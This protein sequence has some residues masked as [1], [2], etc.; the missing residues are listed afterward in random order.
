MVPR[1]PYSSHPYWLRCAK[2][3]G[4]VDVLTTSLLDD[5]WVK[6]HY[7]SC[8]PAFR[9]SQIVTKPHPV[10]GYRVVDAVPDRR[11][12]ADLIG[13]VLLV[14]IAILGATLVLLIGGPT[15]ADAQAEAE[16][17]NAVI[18]MQELD[19]RVS[20]VAYTSDHGTVQ[21]I[22]VSA[23]DDDGALGT[24]ER[25]WIR[26]TIVNATTGTT[27][28]AL[29]NATL[30]TVHYTNGDT[31]VGFEGGGVWRSDR[32]GAVMVTPPA[33]SFHDRTLTLPIISLAGDPSLS[34][35]I[36]TNRAGPTV[37]LFPN[38]SE[39]RANPIDGVKVRV[40]V[41]SR[42]YEAWARYFAET[43][44]ASVRVN[45]TAETATVTF[46]ASNTGPSAFPSGIL[47]TSGNGH[48]RFAGSGAYTD[49]YDSSVGPYTD[50]R[51][52]NGTVV[53]AGDIKST[54]NSSVHG[55]VWSGSTVD[56]DGETTVNGDIY[57]TEAYFKDGAAVAGADTEIPGVASIE[58]IDWLVW[59]RVDAIRAAN[60]NNDT[61]VIQDARLNISDD[62]DGLPTET[63]DSGQYYL[64]RLVLHGE[65]LVLNTSGGNI[66]IAVRDY[67]QLDRGGPGNPGSNITVTG[68]GVV[69]IYVANRDKLL[70]EKGGDNNLDRDRSLNL[71]VSQESTTAIQ[72][73]VAPQLR[74][75]GPRGFTMAMAGSDSKVTYFNGYVY[76]PAGYAG[77]GYTYLKH[78]EV[79]G[80]I[81]TGNLTVG[82][83][84][85]IH[86]DEALSRRT[87]PNAPGLSRIEYLHATVARVN[88]SSS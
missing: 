78:A 64:T 38:R 69:R 60:D 14:G 63:L 20:N 87:I 61:P 9:A 5:S 37:Q 18:A 84:A 43:T 15:L 45:R 13:I 35:A 26:V 8:I 73:N 24:S 77:D 74:I 1:A 68:D 12:L 33:F 85:A 44:N 36:R 67:I 39:S 4:R 6:D 10:E 80:G 81:I 86:Y 47:A 34:N 49:S 2:L 54:G 21:R 57:W 23:I 19:R 59:E 51:H 56:L 17:S 66:T 42:F 41:H 27:A 53:A 71:Y 22:D 75:F 40:T 65:R 82:Q 83:G 32:K 31:T 48:L 29:T 25:N 88:V 52:G 50:S 72:G 62:G 55:D 70:V 28:T 76:A 3:S 46:P 30:G 16:V 79:Y 58:P 7:L 11:A